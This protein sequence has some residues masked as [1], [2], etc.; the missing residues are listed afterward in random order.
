[1]LYKFKKIIKFFGGINLSKRQLEKIADQLRLLSWA[2]GAILLSTTSFHLKFNFGV[3]TII[4]LLWIFLQLI[5]L[6][7]DKR[8]EQK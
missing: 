4:G 3:A 5:S 2:L 6:M 7:L 1:M 8:S